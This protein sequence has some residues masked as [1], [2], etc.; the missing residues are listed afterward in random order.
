MKASKVLCQGCIGYWC[1]AIGA[2][3]K[4]EEVGII[5]VVCEFEDVFR[6]E[7]LGLPMPRKIDFKI[8]LIPR[9]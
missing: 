4:E 2:Q 1:Y 7:L 8:E 9:A 5:I 3:T 6:E